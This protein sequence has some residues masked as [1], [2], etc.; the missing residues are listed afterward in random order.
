[1]NAILVRHAMSFHFQRFAAVYRCAQFS[2]L[3]P[4]GSLSFQ[5]ENETAIPLLHSKEPSFLLSLAPIHMYSFI[6]FVLRK[7]IILS[8]STWSVILANSLPISLQCFFASTHVFFNVLE[9][10]FATSNLGSE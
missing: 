6:L 8:L 3:R 4:L 7:A 5:L 1:M 9:P 10:F 2:T